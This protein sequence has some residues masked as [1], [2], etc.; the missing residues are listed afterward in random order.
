MKESLR[1]YKICSLQLVAAGERAVK[2]RLIGV[3]EAAAHKNRKGA[4]LVG[5]NMEGPFI[6]PKKVG[7]QNTEYVPVSYTHLTLPTTPYV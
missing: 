5:I 2:R 1:F 7:A 3:L 4:D 6:S